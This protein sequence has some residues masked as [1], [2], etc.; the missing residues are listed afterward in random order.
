[1]IG[2]S[3]YSSI[4]TLEFYEGIGINVKKSPFNIQ[5]LNQPVTNL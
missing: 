4:G 5:A 3:L 1:M 2:Q